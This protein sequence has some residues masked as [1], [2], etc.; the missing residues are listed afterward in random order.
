M[1]EHE[2]DSENINNVNWPIITVDGTFLHFMDDYVSLILYQNR[3][4]P[5]KEDKKA[6]PVL[7]R[8]VMVDARL[9]IP[10]LQHIMMTATEGLKIHKMSKMVGGHKSFWG[11]TTFADEHITTEKSLQNVSEI[12]EADTLNGFLS[13]TFQNVNDEGKKKISEFFAAFIGDNVEEI[14]NIRDR[15]FIDKGPKECFRI[16]ITISLNAP[17]VMVY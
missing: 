7:R 5:P 10:T 2:Y 4:Y 8:E 17:V 1:S 12:S 6:K 14:K 13:D 3:V 15:Y 16:Q 11:D 9:S